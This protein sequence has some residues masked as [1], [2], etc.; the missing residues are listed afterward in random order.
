M[1]VELQLDR[2]AEISVVPVLPVAGV[3][4]SV[5]VAVGLPGGGRLVLSAGG[6]AAVDRLAAALLVARGHLESMADGGGG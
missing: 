6:A 5:D 2:V 3:A 1:Y 4:G